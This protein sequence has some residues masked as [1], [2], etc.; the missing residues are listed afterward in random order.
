M[1]I[2]WKGFC[3]L[4]IAH[5][6]C[7]QAFMLQHKCN[8]TDLNNR[9][10]Q[11]VI[12]HSQI[13]IIFNY[14]L[15]ILDIFKYSIVQSL[16]NNH[17]TCTTSLAWTSLSS[18]TPQTWSSPPRR[19]ALP[20]YHARSHTQIIVYAKYLNITSLDFEAKKWKLFHFK[21]NFQ[22]FNLNN[23]SVSWVRS[24]DSHILTVDR[25][26]FISDHRL[27]SAHKTKKN[28]LTVDRETFIS[29]DR[30]TSS[31]ELWP[32]HPTSIG[33]CDIS[34][35]TPC[36]PVNVIWEGA[37]WRSRFQE[38]K[39]N[40]NQNCEQFMLSNSGNVQKRFTLWLSVVFNLFGTQ[41]TSISWPW[42]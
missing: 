31:I 24:M 18:T 35:R 40:S 27:T 36:S 2:G 34:F 15:N 7:T 22:V 38:L 17:R 37:R 12:L 32:P 33:Q 10:A 5:C 6:K 20:T 25:E 8:S 16:F 28:F 42:L 4:H 29:D 23:K 14:S 39:P 13:Y 26:T 19:V 1:Y 9:G 21:L 11:D 3:T 30:S 41:I